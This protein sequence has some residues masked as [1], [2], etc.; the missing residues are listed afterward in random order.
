MQQIAK[1][2]GV[3]LISGVVGALGAIIAAGVLYALGLETGLLP[4]IVGGIWSGEYINSEI[5]K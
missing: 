5:W 4:A 1:I 3:A 2:L